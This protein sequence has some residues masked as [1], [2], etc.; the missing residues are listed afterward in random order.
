MCVSLLYML[1]LEMFHQPCWFELII[2][3]TEIQ[4]C[5][6]L[7]ICF[8][9]F[10][11]QRAGRSKTTEAGPRTKIEINSPRSSFT[12]QN[13]LNNQH[14]N[15]TNEKSALRNEIQ[16]SD[17]TGLSICRFYFIM[18]FHCRFC[19]T[20]LFMYLLLQMFDCWLLKVPLSSNLLVIV[21]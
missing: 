10:D 16:R 18:L 12:N 17:S 8:Y 4:A 20:F 3:F 11:L 15:V 2:Y 19:L 13:E 9:W 21:K 14:S 1:Y 6:L 7:H 5:I